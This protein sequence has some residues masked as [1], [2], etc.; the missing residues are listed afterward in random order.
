VSTDDTV[1]RLIASIINEGRRQIGLNKNGTGIVYEPV[2]ELAKRL[3][4][5]GIERFEIKRAL[6]QIAAEAK[7][8]AHELEDW[9]N[10]IA[11]FIKLAKV[12]RR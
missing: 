9:A 8:K 5:A 7:A 3:R 10:D 11:R 12:P 4:S 2:P 6:A 1:E